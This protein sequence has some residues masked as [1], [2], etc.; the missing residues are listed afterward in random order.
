[1]PNSLLSFSISCSALS[2]T[3]T[4]GPLLTVCLGLP[5]PA[6]QVHGALPPLASC[7]PFLSDSPTAPPS[8]PLSLSRSPIVPHSLPTLPAPFYSN[9]FWPP[10]PS[11]AAPAPPPSLPPPLWSVPLSLLSHPPMAARAVTGTAPCNRGDVIC[12][13]AC[14][15]MC[16]F[17]AIIWPCAGHPTI[18]HQSCSG[19][20]LCRSPGR[21]SAAR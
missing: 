3:V 1:M 4:L 15:V 8:L 11:L 19:R 2:L 7:S 5:L 21:S 9:S 10:P 18:E 6:F 16:L 12:L 20:G 13:G 14:H 17:L